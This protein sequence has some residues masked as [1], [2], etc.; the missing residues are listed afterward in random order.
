MQISAWDVFDRMFKE[1]NEVIIIDDLDK[2]HW[3]KIQYW[4]DHSV[5]LYRTGGSRKR[6][7]WLNVAL[8]ANDGFPARKLFGAD[9]SSSAEKEKS[10]AE[11][12]RGA[13]KQQFHLKVSRRFIIRDPF[14]VVCDSAQLFNEGNADGHWCKEDEEFILLRKDDAV[15]LIYDIPSLLFMEAA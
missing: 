7:P 4:D 10:V 5:T 13:L 12:I 3:G 15:A 8:I 2:F 9:G 1:G 6:I 11:T 14:E